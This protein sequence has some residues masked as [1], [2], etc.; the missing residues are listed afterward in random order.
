MSEATDVMS[1]SLLSNLISG[2]MTVSGLSKAAMA[3]LLSGL[4]KLVVAP[5][6]SMII[7]FECRIVLDRVT[8]DKELQEKRWHA[9]HAWKVSM[10]WAFIALGFFV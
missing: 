8:A 3:V 4:A 10:I 2:L 6:I 7:I 5:V 1:G 9:R